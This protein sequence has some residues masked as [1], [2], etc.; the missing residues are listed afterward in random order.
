MAYRAKPIHEFDKIPDQ[1]YL[2]R[3]KAAARALG[4]SKFKV[5]H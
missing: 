3:V 1:I 5:T 2:V 4:H